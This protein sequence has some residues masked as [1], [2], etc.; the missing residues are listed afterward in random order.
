MLDRG[1]CWALQYPLRYDCLLDA[2][3]WV[4]EASR[5]R[6]RDP[7]EQ[8]DFDHG[9]APRAPVGGV[10]FKT[11][12]E[13]QGPADLTSSALFFVNIRIDIIAVLERKDLAC[14]GMP[15]VP[16][17]C[18]GVPSPPSPAASPVAVFFHMRFWIAMGTFFSLQPFGG[19]TRLCSTLRLVHL[20]RTFPFPHEN[21]IPT[22]R[23]SCVRHDGSKDWRPSGPDHPRLPLRVR[24]ISTPFQTKL[25]LLSDL[26]RP[27]P[28]EEEKF[29][30][31]LR[32]GSPPFP[33]SLPDAMSPID[34]APWR[35]SAGRSLRVAAHLPRLS[36][37]RA[38]VETCIS[39]D[40][41]R[42]ATWIAMENVR[43]SCRTWRGNGGKQVVGRTEG[44]SDRNGR[45]AT[46]K[47]CAHGWMET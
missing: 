30:E 23:S 19:S 43:E 47:E 15:I 38:S 37:G 36:R 10:N 2:I 7:G 44:T 33:V 31:R 16:C 41:R 20:D 39:R 46:E 40:V 24:I 14:V 27:F 34:H 35:H 8:A 4:S 22:R 9:R 6:R 12:N 42:S 13:E 5:R 3:D 18:L 45:N 32:S 11:G 21:G 26:H 25:L 1:G 17:V 28:F 29:L